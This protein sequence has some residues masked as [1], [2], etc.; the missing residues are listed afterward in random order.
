MVTDRVFQRP[1]EFA[2]GKE[3]VRGGKEKKW[4]S[5]TEKCRRESISKP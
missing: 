3:V 5:H 1:A 4:L 2:A